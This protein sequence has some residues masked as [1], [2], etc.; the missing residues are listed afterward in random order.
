MQLIKDYSNDLLI[1]LYK[2]IL[3]EDD[4]GEDAS[5]LEQ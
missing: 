1:D 2:S 5:L 3:P 4:R